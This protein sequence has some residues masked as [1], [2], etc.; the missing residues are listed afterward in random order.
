MYDGG[1]LRGWY[2]GPGSLWDENGN[3]IYEGDFVNGEYNGQ[4]TL[5]ETSTGRVLAEGQFKRNM[6]I[7]ADAVSAPAT[8]ETI[9]G[10]AE[11]TIPSPV[12]ETIPGP[13]EE[14]AAN[15]MIDDISSPEEEAADPETQTDGVEV[16]DLG[17]YVLMRRKGCLCQIIPKLQTQETE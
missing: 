5:Y 11:E 3:L 6:P 15:P 12:E 9:P 14:A 10:P 16:V 7:P 1:F 8:E 17:Q 4:G 13:V 2:Y